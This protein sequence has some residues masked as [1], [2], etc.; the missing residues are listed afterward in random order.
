MRISNIDSLSALLDRLVTE[1]IKWHT[2]VQQGDAERAGH[3]ELLVAEIRQRTSALIAECLS[4]GRYGCLKENRTYAT[5][6]FIEELEALVHNNF[7][8]GE[9]DKAKVAA[10]EALV[11]HELRARRANEG[12]ALNKNNLDQHFSKLVAHTVQRQDPD[13]FAEAG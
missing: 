10:L 13:A 9:A 11:S 3:Q 12:R 7:N 8:L 6:G 1:R 5:K 4:R 2:F